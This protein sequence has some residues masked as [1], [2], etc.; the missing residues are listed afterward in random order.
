MDKAM[1]NKCGI[2]SSKMKRRA[3]NWKYC[4]DVCQLEADRRIRRESYRRHR[5]K[6]L[7]TR[8]QKYLATREKVLE[9]SRIRYAEDREYRERKIA[10]AK[11]YLQANREKCNKYHK[12]LKARKR[13]PGINFEDYENFQEERRRIYRQIRELKK[14]ARDSRACLA[15]GASMDGYHGSRKYCD[16]HG[17]TGYKRWYAA[18][19][20]HARAESRKNT[21]KY[22]EKHPDTIKAKTLR[23]YW[24]NPEK[25][26]KESREYF[27]KN[28]DRVLA[29]GRRRY[30]NDPESHREY[31]KKYSKANRE[32]INEWKRKWRDGN[33]DKYRA[34]ARADYAK[35]RDERLRKQEY[36]N[37][38]MQ[39][40]QAYRQMRDRLRQISNKLKQ[41]E[42]GGYTNGNRTKQTSRSY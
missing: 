12:A 7:A 41:R 18:N 14:A 6:T 15:C 36:P 23:R 33:R 11:A 2:C 3:G 25:Y 13:H 1:A 24:S 20:E 17:D 29:E 4:S 27:G 37:A 30:W 9:D 34:A 32:K 22:C 42:T 10:N 40:F 35:H 16:A 28:R 5:D 31:N 21:R 19:L 39:A 8:K 26:R 38:D